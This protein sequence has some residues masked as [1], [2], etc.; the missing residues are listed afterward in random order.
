MLEAWDVDFLEV[1]YGY[2]HEPWIWTGGPILVNLVP[3]FFFFPLVREKTIIQTNKYLQDNDTNWKVQGMDSHNLH[4]QF[5]P[6]KVNKPSQ[7]RPLKLHEGWWLQ[8]VP[9][10]EV[11]GYQ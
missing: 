6:Y 2:I 11:Q 5:Q 1:S 7:K 8:R 3:V 10:E 4:V 9:Q